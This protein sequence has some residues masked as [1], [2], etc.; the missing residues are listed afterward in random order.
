MRKSFITF[1]TIAASILVV[2]G[3]ISV[4]AATVIYAQNI[5]T[6]QEVNHTNTTNTMKLIKKFNPTF[7]IEAINAKIKSVYSDGESST[8][9][10]TSIITKVKHE[11]TN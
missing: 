1:M 5:S 3:I 8:N 6:I 2:I 10:T 4:T 9:P 7:I 11:Q